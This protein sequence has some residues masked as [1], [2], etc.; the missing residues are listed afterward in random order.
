MNI[1]VAIT[2]D[3]PLVL[4][5]LQNVILFYDHLELAGCYSS[6]AALI[7][8]LAS[9][10]PDV[11]LLDIQL[12]D[13]TGNELVRV[14]TKKYP[15][16]KILALTNV[17]TKFHITDMMQHGCMGYLT[18]HIDE[19]TLVKAIETIYDGEHFVEEKL[20]AVLLNSMIGKDRQTSKMTPLTQREKEILQLIAAE[21]T[22]QEIADK[23]FI[24]IRT[25][26]NHRMSIIQKLGAKNTVGL[27]KSA[28]E[29]GLI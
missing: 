7:E 29:L 2:D 3:H 19:A 18:K 21:H 20:K 8:G 22:N 16:I 5:G 6:G 17:E 13:T 11:L 25:V 15:L 14:I 4:K 10:Q 1:K 24:A 27:I 28:I 9:Q 26:E 12:Q 23:L